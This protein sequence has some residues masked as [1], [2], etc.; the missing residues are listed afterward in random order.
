GAGG[1]SNGSRA[2]SDRAAPRTASAGAVSYLAPVVT[3]ELLAERE[4]ALAALQ[5]EL[6]AVRDEGGN[7]FCANKYW[8][9]RVAPRVTELVGAQAAA[10]DPL[11]SAPEAYTVAYEVLYRLLPNCRNCVCVPW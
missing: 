1:G 8:Y 4:P 10:D 9:V 11:L 6:S 3:W 7:S 5:L 2:R